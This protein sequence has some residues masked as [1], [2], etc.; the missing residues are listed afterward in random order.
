LKAATRIG[1]FACVLAAGAP[2]WCG[3]DDKS[4]VLSKEELATRYP[5]L[6]VDAIHDSPI[7]GLYEVDYGKNIRYVTTDGRFMIKGDIVELSNQANLTEA[8]R[9]KMRADLFATIDPANA[10]VFSPKD[11]NVKYRVIVFT[12]VDCG[13]CR[14]FH[15]G[16]EEVNALGIEVRYVSYPRTGPNSE[17]WTKAERVWCATDRKAAL[18]QAKLGAEPAAVADCKSTPVADE[19]ELGRKVGLTGT[20]G[21]YSESGV[22]LGG[23]L[24][25]KELL[26]QLQAIPAAK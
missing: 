7:P 2:A 26:A 13:Y 15:R 24:A 14:E 12:D 23:Y 11:G 5:G 19:Y 20:P 18:T 25:P 8:R 3:A 6:S 10:I 9:A 16:I 21:L 17:S 22:E 1:F 4:P